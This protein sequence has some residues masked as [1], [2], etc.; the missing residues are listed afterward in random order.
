MDPLRPPPPM[1]LND[2]DVEVLLDG[3]Q[4]AASQTTQDSFHCVDLW[5]H[6]VQNAR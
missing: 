3:L 6:E 4:Y 1:F 2:V 5:H